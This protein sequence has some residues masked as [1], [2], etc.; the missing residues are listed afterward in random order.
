SEIQC[1]V[2]PNPTQG[3]AY[4]QINNPNSQFLKISISHLSGKTLDVIAAGHY[5][6]GRYNLPLSGPSLH[7]KPGVYLVKTENAAGKINIKKLVLN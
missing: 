1:T 3:Q 2:Y 7:L 5:S 4:L 6:A